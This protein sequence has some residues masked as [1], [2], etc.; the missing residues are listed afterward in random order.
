M[1]APEPILVFALTAPVANSAGPT[2]LEA[3]SELP[4]ESAAKL[5]AVSY[6]H[7]TLPTT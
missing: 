1:I 5:T 7:L 6:T 4:T 2:A 3:I